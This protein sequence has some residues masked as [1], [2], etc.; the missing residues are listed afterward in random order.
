[1]YWRKECR[2][3]TRAGLKTGANFSV[4][5]MRGRNMADM[6]DLCVYSLKKKVGITVQCHKRA[7]RLRNADIRQGQ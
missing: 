5:S 1:M 4:W 6:G 2:Y 7:G 3:D